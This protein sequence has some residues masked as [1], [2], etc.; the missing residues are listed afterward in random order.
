MPLTI[1]IETSRL[2]RLSPAGLRMIYVHFLSPA[3]ITA[4]IKYLARLESFE[5]PSAVFR[6][7]D[8]NY[9]YAPCESRALALLRSSHS[10]G[11]DL[12]NI[13][14]ADRHP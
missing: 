2:Y 7:I 14:R 10:V 13:A 9:V 12:R 5:Q 4:L 1:P 6:I 11:G 3:Y 8:R